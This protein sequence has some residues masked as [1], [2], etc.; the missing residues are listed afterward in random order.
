MPKPIQKSLQ[1]YLSKV[2]KPSTPHIHFP[3][4]TLSSSTSWILRGCKHPKTLSFAVNHNPN[5]VR[6]NDNDAATLEDIDRFLFENFKSFFMNDDDE[7]TKKIGNNCKDHEESGGSSLESPRFVDPPQD[8]CGSNRFF[9]GASSSSSLV[10]K[11]RTRATTS[12]DTSST[13]TTTSD[14]MQVMGPDDF[15]TVLTYSPSPYDDFRNSMMEMIEAR[16]HH[17]GEVDWEFMEEILFCFLDLNDQK[18]YKYILSAFVDLIVVLRENSGKVP[19]RSGHVRS[20]GSGRE[21]K[22]GV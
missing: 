7:D 2:K 17:Q 6:K 12:E 5:Q 13:S 1:D 9:V 22:E 19:A 16:M 18:S 4:K 20:E 14:A 10:E 11:S 21:R 8:L 15:I 3:S